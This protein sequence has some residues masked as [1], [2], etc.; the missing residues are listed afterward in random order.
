VL[1]FAIAL[2][3]AT[4]ALAVTPGFVVAGNGSPGGVVA[5]A[6]AVGAA[7]GMAL[8]GYVLH[9]RPGTHD[10]VWWAVIQGGLMGLTLL[11][12]FAL[13]A[14]VGPA[15]RPNPALGG[16]AWLGLMAVAAIAGTAS[17]VLWERIRRRRRTG[18]LLLLAIC[19]L[20]AG[21]AGIRAADPWPMIGAPPL[22]IGVIALVVALI[23][24]WSDLIDSAGST[25]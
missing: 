14:L 24:G 8:R 2:A 1:L 11:G 5:F 20:A 21:L 10:G 22:V 18:A 7:A 19:L 4:L 23:A 17:G 6:P 15:I 12:V 13:A 9:R 16:D 3:C 25:A